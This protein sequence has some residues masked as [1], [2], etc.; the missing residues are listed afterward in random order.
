MKEEQAVNIIKGKLME[1]YGYREGLRIAGVIL[2]GIFADFR[3][4]AASAGGAG[5]SEEYKTE[6]LKAVITLEGH[7]DRKQLIVD[8]LHVIKS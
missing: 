6:D 8:S 4:M 5:V 2:P 1:I 3:Q 7:S